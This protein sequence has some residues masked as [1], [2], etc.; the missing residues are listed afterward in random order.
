MAAL[1]TR[2]RDILL[3]LLNSEVPISCN[4]IA[5]RLGTSPRV[6]NYSLRGVEIWLGQRGQ[7]LIKKSGIGNFLDIPASKKKSLI[8][9][10][11][12][13]SGYDLILN[14]KER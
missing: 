1:D 12:K 13:I 9:E 3:I 7:S 8:K 5:M 6:I 14:P 2:S 11:E 4:E 10:V